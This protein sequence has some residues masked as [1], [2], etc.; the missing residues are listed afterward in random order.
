MRE[1]DQIIDIINTMK[2]IMNSMRHTMLPVEDIKNV[3]DTTF[4]VN[5]ALYGV[6]RLVNQETIVIND[7]ESYSRW[8]EQLEELVDIWE[9]TILRR[10]TGNEVDKNFWCIYEQFKYVPCDIIY[11][12]TVKNFME[13]PE[14]QRIDFLALPQRYIFLHGKIDIVENDFSLIKEYIV[15]MTENVEKFKWFYEVLGDYRSKKVLIGIVSFWLDFNLRKLH[16][17]TETVF[18]DYFDLDLINCDQEEVFVDCGA[19]TG[20]SSLDFVKT[21][22]KYAK[23]YAFELAPSTYETLVKNT[24]MLEN[25]ITIQKGVGQTKK[26]IYIKDVENGA[27]NSV[28][29]EG[30]TKVEI[31]TLDD[32]ID[33]KITLI[34]M[35]IEGAEKDAILGA[36]DHIMNEKPRMM[37][38]TYHLP[39]DIFTIPFLVNEIRDDYKF[40]MRFNGH[41]GIWPCDYVLFAI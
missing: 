22:G 18:D 28:F 19:Y 10:T 4:E 36:K 6:Q 8:V 29:R 27:G 26:T 13:L 33:E 35:D 20:D 39:E 1:Y 34:K 25:V 17:L 7:E 31:T 24:Q 40:Y 38:S 16:M 21:Y 32:E 41:N 15:M 11:N 5:N 30:D 37:I 9:K 23:I 14:A 3:V 12:N 2:T